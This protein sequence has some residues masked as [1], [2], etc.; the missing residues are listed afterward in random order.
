MSIKDCPLE[1][2]QRVEQ[3]IAS[4]LEETGE[5]FR[6]FDRQDSGNVSYGVRA[7]GRNRFVKYAVQPENVGYLK[8][9]A[10]F[11][12]K[13]SHPCVPRLLNHFPA[14]EGYALVFEW[15]DGEVLG[16]PEFSGKEGRSR[17]DSPHF[18]FRRLPAETIVRALGDVYELHE[19]LE[20]L[21]YVAVDL[22]D[23]SLIYDF[24]RNAL[25]LCDF[26]LYA[27]GAFTLATDRNY[28][29]SRYMAPE[30]FVKGSRI[31]AVTNVFNL[32]AAAF[33]FLAEEEGSR[34]P[35]RWRASGALHRTAMKAV[36]PDRADRFGSVAEFRRAWLEAL[37]SEGAEG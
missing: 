25:H 12:A 14:G 13:V 30:E 24:A 17:P 35:A 3:D 34:D 11:H 20:R 28:G 10:A 21:G 4:F 36:S 1:A 8:N 37:R 29:S 9:A 33:V 2:A 32:G 5:V 23:G 31:D 19:Q 15:V 6:I 22:Y 26:D 7:A 27:K 16:S 18:R